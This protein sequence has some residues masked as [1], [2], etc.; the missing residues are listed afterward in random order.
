MCIYAATKAAVIALSEAIQ[1]SLAADHIGVSVLMPGPIKSR[2]HEAAQN[3]PERFRKHSG[4][5]ESEAR[6]AKRKVSPLWMEP[7]QVGEMVLNAIRN[8]ELYIITHGEWREAVKGR[9][10]KILSAM[11]TETN[12]ALIE[13]LRPPADQ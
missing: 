9:I 10:D 11:P 1:D 4:F 7:D 3:R 8:N 12:P 13:S 2:I 5:H 6:L